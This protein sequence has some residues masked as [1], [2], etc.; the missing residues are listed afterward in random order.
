MAGFCKSQKLGGWKQSPWAGEMKGRGGVRKAEGSYRYWV[1]L[2]A[3]VS[4]S[5]HPS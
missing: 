3:S 5:V 1:S 4:F 2:G